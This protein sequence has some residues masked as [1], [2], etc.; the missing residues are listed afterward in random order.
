MARLFQAL[1]RT[2][3]LALAAVAAQGIP[4]VAESIILPEAQPL[5]DPLLAKFDVTL[6]GVRC[7]LAV[8]QAREAARTDRH[9]D[10][11][12]LDV[13]D[14][15]IVHSKTAL[16]INTATESTQGAVHRILSTLA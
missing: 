10:P 16:G 9:N 5:Y 2:H 6:I 13:P 4:V 11:V 14:F 7:P 15:T 1:V 12:E 8:A 3:L